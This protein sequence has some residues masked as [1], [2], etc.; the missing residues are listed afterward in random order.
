[1]RSIYHAPPDLM[2]EIS[3]RRLLEVFGVLADIHTVK[4]TESVHHESLAAEYERLVLVIQEDHINAAE[5]HIENET[6]RANL[7]DEIKAECQELIDFRLAAERWRLEID[8]RSK[9]RI[10]SFGEKLSCRVVAALLQDR[11]GPTLL[12]LGVVQL[13]S[14]VSRASIR[15]SWMSRMSFPRKLARPSIS[16][17]SDTWLLS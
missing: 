14:L 2:S 16:T 10:V 3:S 9:D 4:D 1:M 15:N 17:S 13:I 8:S 7:V 6:I 5:S 12:G 11:V